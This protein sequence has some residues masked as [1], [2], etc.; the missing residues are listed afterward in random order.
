MTNLR[1]ASK[2]AFVNT[3]GR[4]PDVSGVVEKL[5]CWIR[6]SRWC[7]AHRPLLKRSDRF[8][9][10]RHENR[11]KLYEAVVR[12]EGLDRKPVHFLEFGVYEGASISWWIK[13][14][15]HSGARF[16]GFD[17]FL[18]LPEA[19]HPAA[20]ARTFSTEGKVP[21]IEDLRCHFE[22]GLFQ[23]TVP[24]FL[25]KFSRDSRL[26]VHLDADLYS[27]TLFVLT[28]IG[29]ILRPGD[30]LFFDE[31]A[32]PR[33]EFRALEDFSRAYRFAYE[34]VAQVSRFNQVCLKAK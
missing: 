18:G 23:D 19:W 8:A 16:V 29:S 7:I 31:F 9:Q 13:R 14:I 15:S 34:P 33:H 6:F 10:Q 17:T 12:K 11:Y 21:R 3:V 4:L 32:S 25:Q 28:S 2:V 1:E 20:P 22:V 5:A 27:S 30:L 24:A 26:V